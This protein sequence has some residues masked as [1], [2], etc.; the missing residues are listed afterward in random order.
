MH[1]LSSFIDSLG[2]NIDDFVLSRSSIKRSQENSRAN[3]FEEI[4]NTDDEAD[5][6]V[7]HWDSKL[8]PDVSGKSTVDRLPIVTIGINLEQLLGVSSISSSTAVKV[9]SAVS[10]AVKDWNLSEKVQA[11][12]LTRRLNGACTLLEQKLKRNVLWLAM[13]MK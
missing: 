12:C 10:A 13:F 11:F 6:V 8:L 2:F 9:S 3:K 4:K 1:L 7:I 5:F